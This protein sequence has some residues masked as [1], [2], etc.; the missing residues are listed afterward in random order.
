[1]HSTH[2][3]RLSRSAA[4]SRCCTQLMC[5]NSCSVRSH[6]YH[7]LGTVRRNRTRRVQSSRMLG[8]GA[9]GVTSGAPWRTPAPGCTR[10]H[11]ASRRAPG[12]SKHPARRPSARATVHAQQSRPQSGRPQ[13]GPA[14]WAP[15]RAA[16]HASSYT[17]SNSLAVTAR[18]QRG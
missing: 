14:E 11:Q 1:M 2:P 7:A 8:H 6:T 10:A 4:L 9:P 18:A 3:T 12:H 13:S 17:R 15:A 5:I 16:R